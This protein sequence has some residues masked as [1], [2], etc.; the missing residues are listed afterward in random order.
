MSWFSN[1]LRYI[2]C[3]DLQAEQDAPV[4]QNAPVARGAGKQDNPLRHR[5]VVRQHP[6]RCRPG[7]NRDKRF[8]ILSALD[9][10]L[11]TLVERCK[12]FS[13]FAK[14]HTIEDQ[15]LRIK[16][17]E[18]MQGVTERLKQLKCGSVN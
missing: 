13:M 2:P 8:P 10:R 16:T 5:L 9:Q 14:Q 1:L 17:S 3:V 6:S 15:K 4:E 18:L 7:P 12:Y 11:D